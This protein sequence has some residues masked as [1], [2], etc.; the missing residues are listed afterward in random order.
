MGK[1]KLNKF[2]LLSLY[3]V[4]GTMISGFHRLHNLILPRAFR[5][6]H[7]NSPIL[8]MRKPYL[9]LHYVERASKALVLDLCRLLLPYLKIPKDLSTSCLKCDRHRF[10]PAGVFHLTFPTRFKNAHFHIFP[11][12]NTALNPKII[13]V[14]LPGNSHLVSQP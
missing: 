13:L 5:G 2:N 11:S 12:E 1:N 14:S 8:Q 7:M 9:R 4:S 10:L 3:Y 6:E